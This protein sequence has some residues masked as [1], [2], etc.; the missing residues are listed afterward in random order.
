MRKGQMNIFSLIGAG[1]TIAI[2]SI[3]SF[4]YQNNRIGTVETRTSVLEVRYEDFD[5]KLSRIEN[6]LD[7]AIFGR[8]TISSS[9][10]PNNERK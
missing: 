3:S 1:V 6:K 4:F 9:S 2:A 8:L 5:K 7:N 10:Q